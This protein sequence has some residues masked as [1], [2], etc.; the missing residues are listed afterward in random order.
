MT[1]NSVLRQVALLTTICLASRA[2]ADEPTIDFSAYRPESGIAIIQEAGQLRV[3]WPLEPG[4]GRLELDLRPDKPLIRTM[5][6]APEAGKP[7]RAVIENADPVTYLLVGS[8]EAPAGRPPGMS[9]FNV[10]FDTPATRPYQSYRGR[11]DLKRVRISTHGRRATIA[12]GDVTIGPFAGELRLT[13]YRGASLAHLETVVHT[14]D[15]RRAILYDTGLA[16]PSA[17]KAR[18]AWVD[19]EG[20]LVRQEASADDADRHLAVRHRA[21][22]VETAGGSVAC[23]PPPHQFFFPRDQTDNLKTVW[24]GRDHRGLDTR[25]GFGIRQAERGG[26]SYVPWFNAPPGTDQRLGVFYLL[27]AGDAGQA[28]RETARYTRGDRYAR[29]AGYHTLTSH[30]HMAA[31][32]AA[33]EEKSR[34]GPRTVPDSVRM[35]KEMGVE[36]VHLAEF[37]GDGH[38]Q[39]PGPVRLAEMDAMFAEC[40]R[41]SDGEVLVLPGEEANIAIGQ[42]RP[43][44]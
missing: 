15:D 29:L 31:T 11:L 42:A 19:T 41:L 34:G 43:G 20:Q 1:R 24:F 5:G 25:F 44:K 16:L 26:G 36:I 23:F 32:M 27:S 40:K 33:L 9:V 17:N 13:F 30:W 21:L 10:F 8:R 37:H 22:I 28:V 35:F 38:P 39:G 18:F 7:T 12:I 14:Q 2:S 3:S 6:F 4:T